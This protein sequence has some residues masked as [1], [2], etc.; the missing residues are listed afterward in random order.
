MFSVVL[1]NGV[2]MRRYSISRNGAEGWEVIRQ[3][4]GERP[5]HVHYRDWHRVERALALFHLEIN[6]LVARGWQQIPQH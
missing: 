6:D 5:R 3:Q 1:H 4:D 2:A